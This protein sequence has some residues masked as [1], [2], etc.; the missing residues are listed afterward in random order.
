MNLPRILIE[1]DNSGFTEEPVYPYPSSIFSI[2]RDAS[3]LPAAEIAASQR[4]AHNFI[5]RAVDIVI[6]LFVILLILP[7][8]VPMVSLSIILDSKGSPFFIQKRVGRHGRYFFCYKFRTMTV[9][10]NPGKKKVT[11]VG[12]ILRDRKLDEILQFVN[13][14]VG[15]MSVVGPRP[16]TEQDHIVFSNA[17]CDNFKRRLHVLPGITGLAQI[18]GYSGVIY[19]RHKLQ[20]R[21]RLDLFYI[22]KWSLA[23]DLWIIWKTFIFLLR[24]D[25]IRKPEDWKGVSLRKY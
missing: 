24:P 3:A 6:S 9:D 5:K 16:H 22:Q 10:G 25:Q 12:Q 18:R 11:R 17:L 15:Q 13:V 21:A 14:L 4:F 1:I 7:W 2:Q 19:S 23:L 8:L 20:G